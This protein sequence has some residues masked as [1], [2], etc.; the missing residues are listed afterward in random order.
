MA[1][2]LVLGRFDSTHMVSSTH[3]ASAS[4]SAS[5]SASS[6]AHAPALES[7]APSPVSVPAVV[8]RRSSKR[9]RPDISDTIP[10]IPVASFRRL[11][12]EISGDIRSD[13][14]WE[15]EALKALHVD[16]EA[17]LIQRFEDAKQRMKMARVKTVDADH[18]SG[19]VK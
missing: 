12:R 11:V 6:S 8:V 19:L 16:A 10:A 7:A 4:V 2:S 5:S 3:A 17:Y 14:R 13:L 1:V 15:G 9:K 18:F